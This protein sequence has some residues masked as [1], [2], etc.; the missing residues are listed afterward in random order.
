M[1][2]NFGTIFLIS[3]F[4]VIIFGSCAKNQV[5]KSV[6]GY[7]YAI[8]RAG[9]GK[10]A[11]LGDYIIF[12]ASLKQNNSEYEL[13]DTSYNPFNMQLLEDNSDKGEMLNIVANVLKNSR[14]GDSV[15][16]YFPYT[17]FDDIVAFPINRTV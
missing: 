14:I 10:K 17:Y 15:E 12:N 1:I 6:D 5:K 3:I 7:D 16:V 9:K 2:I 8:V 4:I 13:L 11:Q